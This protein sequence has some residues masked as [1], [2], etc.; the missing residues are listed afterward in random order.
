MIVPRPSGDGERIV[1]VL[2]ESMV[3]GFPAGFGGIVTVE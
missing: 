2:V 3:A 1:S